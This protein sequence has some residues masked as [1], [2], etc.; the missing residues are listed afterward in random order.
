MS[1]N[2]DVFPASKPVSLW[3]SFDSLGDEAKS[4]RGHNVPVPSV[5]RIEKGMDLAGTEDN[6]S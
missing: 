3:A 1:G 4:R 6:G 2:S 5:G